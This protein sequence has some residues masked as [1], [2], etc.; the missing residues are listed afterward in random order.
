[1]AVANI[2]SWD[3]DSW[4]DDAASWSLGEGPRGAVGHWISIKGKTVDTYQVVDGSTWNASPRDGSGNP[5][6]LEAALVGV[7]VADPAQP[8]EV[9]RVVHSFSPC[10]ACAA[11][12]VDPEAGPLVDVHTR[13]REA[14]R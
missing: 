8:L 10:V 4:P 12:V 9:L 1:V 3:P 13:M 5:G 14:V 11:H 6:P 2:T 7:S